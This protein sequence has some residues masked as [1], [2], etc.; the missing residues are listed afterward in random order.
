MK[1]LKVFIVMFVM[2]S[3]ISSC[4]EKQSEAESEF[5]QFVTDHVA[6]VKPLYIQASKASWDAATSGDP[7][8]Y[9]MRQKYHF[10]LARFIA[11]QTILHC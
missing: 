7:N 6:E 1:L 11:I 5:Q 9:D 2:I 3:L 4:A 10:S 8:D